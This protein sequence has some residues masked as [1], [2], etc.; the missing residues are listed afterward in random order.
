[1]PSV[2]VKGSSTIPSV[3]SAR[4][5]SQCLPDGGHVDPDALEP[6]IRELSDAVA[7]AK[8]VDEL[9]R[10]DDA[11]DLWHQVYPKL[12]EGNPGLVGAMTAR[13]EA[14]VTRLAAIY[15]LL[16][17]SVV[18]R[19]EHLKAA[20]AVWRYCEASVRFIFRDSLGNPTAERILEA[21][22]NSA[23]GLTR[24][25]IRDLL[26]RH[27]DAKAVDA[28]LNLLSEAGLAR[29]EKQPTEGRP[30]EHWFAIVAS[31]VCSAEEPRQ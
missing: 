19:V 16:D 1:M 5:R 30:I 15:A 26:G 11:R 7:F 12:S 8:E 27:A 2:A 22:R 18:I 31:T 24:T 21:L 13:A 29:R 4:V 9:R 28:A 17:K 10:D 25:E 3:S 6:L 14:Q 20:L 23:A